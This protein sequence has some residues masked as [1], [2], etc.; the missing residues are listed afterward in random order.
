M[1]T[2]RVLA[3]YL[4][5]ISLQVRTSLDS[6]SSPVPREKFDGPQSIIEPLLAGFQ[7]EWERTKKAA[8]NAHMLSQQ[9]ME[10]V[11]GLAEG[12]GVNI[13]GVEARESELGRVEERVWQVCEKR[14]LRWNLA[15]LLNQF[16]PDV[17]KVSLLQR[18]S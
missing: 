16:E 11:Q 13:D 1:F 9:L 7:A 18:G 10:S 2:S 12:S 8:G 5:Q 6:L 17:E 14:E 15:I 4:L 3:P